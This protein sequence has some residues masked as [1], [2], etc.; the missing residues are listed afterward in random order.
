MY[1]KSNTKSNLESLV[2]TVMDGIL[3]SLASNVK[4]SLVM[5]RIYLEIIADLHFNCFHNKRNILVMFNGKIK[6]RSK[7]I[8]LKSCSYL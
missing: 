1:V 3:G 6:M 4:G 2:G 8:T 5:F 7:S